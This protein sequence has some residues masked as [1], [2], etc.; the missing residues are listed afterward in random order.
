MAGMYPVVAGS[1]SFLAPDLIKAMD[2]APVIVS[3]RL[4]RHRHRRHDWTGSLLVAGYQFDKGGRS[5]YRG[6]RNLDTISLLWQLAFVGNSRRCC[7]PILS[8]TQRF[9]ITNLLN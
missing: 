2:A 3:G 9:Q 4:D 1:R 6:H 5:W 8:A 7:N